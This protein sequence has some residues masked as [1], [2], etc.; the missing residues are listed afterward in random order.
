MRRFAKGMALMGLLLFSTSALAQEG[1]VLSQQNIRL[2][3]DMDFGGQTL[4]RGTYQVTLTEVD[5]EEWFVL[6]KGGTEAARDLAIKLPAKELPTQ[7][8]KAEF[9]TR[10]EYYRV[11]VRKDDTVYVIH[12][13]IKGAKQV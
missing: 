12:F 1:N 8:W 13:L 11:R 9:L 6:K 3:R 7:G 5:G 10:G 4:A 2:P